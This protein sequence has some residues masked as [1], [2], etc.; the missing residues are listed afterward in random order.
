VCSSDLD[1][2]DENQYLNLIEDI[3]EE[4]EEF[5]GR[6]GT[7]YA[8]F[9]CAMHFSLDDNI[10]PFLTTKK[11]AWKTCLRELLWFIKGSTSNKELNDKNVHIWDANASKEFLSKQG[12]NYDSRTISNVGRGRKRLRNED[13]RSAV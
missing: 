2:H 11:L 1:V 7:T 3:L 4:N 9:G 12:L 13:D 6:N 5:V 10:V 8:V